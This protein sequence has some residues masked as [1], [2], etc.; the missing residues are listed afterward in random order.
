MSGF[1]R[2]RTEPLPRVERVVGLDEVLRSIPQQHAKAFL[3]CV[4]YGASTEVIGEKLG[5]TP[6]KAR[7]LISLGASLLR[8]PSRTMTLR[9]YLETDGQTLLIDEGLRALLREWRLEEMFAPE[10]RQCGHRYTPKGRMHPMREGGR[11]RQYCSN[12]CRQKA[13]RERHR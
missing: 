10:C 6:E 12:A 7:H 9:E 2:G 5:V 8:H 3:A 1:W 4:L 11:P 13:Y